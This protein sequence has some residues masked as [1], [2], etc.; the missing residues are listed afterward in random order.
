MMGGM[1]AHLWIWT[2]V[3][4]LFIVLLFVV[5]TKLLRRRR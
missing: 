3:G 2:I 4:V 1:M 5:I